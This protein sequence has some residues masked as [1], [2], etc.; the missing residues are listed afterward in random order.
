MTEAHMADSDENTVQEI[1]KWLH[2]NTQRELH[3]TVR[4]QLE[5]P[6][7][8]YHLYLE[9]TYKALTQSNPLGEPV[10]SLDT[11]PATE[12]PTQPPT[13][14]TAEDTVTVT[15]YITIGPK[16]MM[17]PPP[18]YPMKRQ[19][20]PPNAVSD[21][22]VGPKRE[23]PPTRPT[24]NT[25]YGHKRNYCKEEIYSCPDRY[26]QSYG[27]REGVAISQSRLPV[28]GQGLFGIKPSKHNPLLFKQTHFLK[29]IDLI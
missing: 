5:H 1:L 7:E 27:K 17:E 13:L 28:A 4:Q 26:E 15:L 3:Q 10:E 14:C 19:I 22:Q 25:S 16:E 18:T 9:S 29:K 21:Q 12:S 23:P 6:N 2:W 11:L 20:V 24:R 8:Q